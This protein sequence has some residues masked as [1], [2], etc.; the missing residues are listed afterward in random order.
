MIGRVSS[1][2]FVGRR[3]ELAA[4][5]ATLAQARAGA[6][7][8]ALVAGDAG[9]G[10][11][12]LI[13]ELARGAERDGMTVMLGE[14][15]P[16][17]DGELP[18][19]PIMTALRSLL[20]NG[21]R[22]RVEAWL[23]SGRSEL[24][25]LL[26]ELASESAIPGPPPSQLSQGQLFE[27]LLAV[28]RAAA[29]ETPLM[30]VIEDFHWA[31]R[32]TRDFLA[33]LVRAAR[34]EA[35]AVVVSY[36]PDELHRRHPAR[37][38]V[39]DLERV[40]AATKIELG[41]L[42]RA[43][44]RDQVSAILDSPPPPLLL[45]TLLERSEGNPFFAEELLAASQGDTGELPRSLRDTLLTRVEMHDAAVQDVLRIAAV[46]RSD[47]RARVPRSGGKRAGG[48]AQSRAPR[49]GR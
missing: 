28:L 44:L 47:R 27:Q 31:D 26:P 4:L 13:G 40:G 19:A 20:R 30:L 22:E 7:A 34:R 15:L 39:L 1:S 48:R 18:Y 35:I 37:P 10:K 43:E 14:C 46:A 32:S 33:Y 5:E 49:G 29:A 3:E 21:D 2:R 41:P 24:A 6:G 45:D 42:T 16:L 9:L 36:R 8:L 25:V 11:S 23:S 17:G 38:F 12:R